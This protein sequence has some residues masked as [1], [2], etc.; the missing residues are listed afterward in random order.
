VRIEVQPYSN[1]SEPETR[2]MDKS[3]YWREAKFDVCFRS[4]L[5]DHIQDYS[6]EFAVS[7]EHNAFEYGS[8]TVVKDAD[9]SFSFTMHI[10]SEERLSEDITKELTAF[11]LDK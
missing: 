10:D 9:G 4:I 6:N 11:I 5:E 3:E 8:L 7:D 2:V 1:F